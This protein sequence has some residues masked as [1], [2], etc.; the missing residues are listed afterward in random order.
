MSAH[1]FPQLQPGK[2]RIKYKIVPINEHTD[3]LQFKKHR[4]TKYLFYPYFMA[5]AMF[6]VATLEIK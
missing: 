5:Q 6:V 3:N 1:L 4:T 2:E